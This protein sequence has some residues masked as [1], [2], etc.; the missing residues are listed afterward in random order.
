MR[1]RLAPRPLLRDGIPRR[2]VPPGVPVNMGPERNWGRS[3]SPG[4]AG[5][6]PA[7]PRQ[8]RCRPVPFPPM[9]GCSVEAPERSG[10]ARKHRTARMASWRGALVCTDGN[11]A[12]GCGSGSRLL[13]GMRP[14]RM[15]HGMRVTDILVRATRCRISAASPSPRRTQIRA[16][17]PARLPS[18]KVFVQPSQA[19][20]QRQRFTLHREQRVPGHRIS[21]ALFGAGCRA[22]EARGR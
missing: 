18:G 16:V 9:G 20:L 14:R 6:P 4:G 8:P 10:G 11:I 13:R 15:H 2:R 21:A 1:A 5:I 19:R 7:G 12:M 17:A 22:S 3:P